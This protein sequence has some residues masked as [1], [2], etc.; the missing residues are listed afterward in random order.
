MNYTGLIVLII[1]NIPVYILFGK[2]FF[3]SRDDFG[4]AVAMILTP[5]IVAVFQGDF[6]NRWWVGSKMMMWL[7]LCF[8]TVYFEYIKIGK[9]TGWW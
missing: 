8:A 7:L 3:K 2:L 1:L 9:I 6:W 4:E 5:E